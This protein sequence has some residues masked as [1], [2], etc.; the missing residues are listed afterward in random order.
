MIG[1]YLKNEASV[2]MNDQYNMTDRE[3]TLYCKCLLCLFDAI[4]TPMIGQKLSNCTVYLLRL[5]KHPLFYL[6]DQ[7]DIIIAVFSCMR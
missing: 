1:K 6:G 3:L 5:E 4:S 2:C 7:P